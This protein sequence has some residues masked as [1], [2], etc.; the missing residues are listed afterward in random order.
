MMNSEKLEKHARRLQAIMAR[1]NDPGAT[2]AEQETCR[3]IAARIREKYP[4]LADLAIEDGSC[5]L[6]WTEPWQ[7]E[8]LEHVGA[9]LDLSVTDEQENDKRKQKSMLFSGPTWLVEVVEYVY[10]QQ[11]PLLQRALDV[12]LYGYMNGAMPLPEEVQPLP[13]PGDRTWSGG[14]EFPTGHS[15]G[16]HAGPPADHHITVGMLDA[17]DG[18]D[19]VLRESLRMGRRHQADTGRKRLT[20]KNV[21]KPW[22]DW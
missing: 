11:R 17:L 2:P 1:A 4:Q 3:T 22:G 7:R 10:D 18:A 9:W 16:G 21:R 5:R 8:L 20:A 6:L 19:G 12:T 15:R 13:D 14:A